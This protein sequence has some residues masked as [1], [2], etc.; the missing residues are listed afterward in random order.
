MN[1][2]LSDAVTMLLGRTT[3][4]LTVRLILQPSMAAF[5]AIRAGL[6]DARAGRTPYLSSVVR[7]QAGQRGGLLREGWQQVRTIFFVA[8]ALDVIYQIMVFRWVY[9]LQAVI[10]AVVLATL[11]ILA[12][13]GALAAKVGGAPMWVG[14]AR[15]TFWGALAMGVTAGVGALFH[16][17]V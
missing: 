7:A 1:E 4:P 12:I 2:F 13:L 10:V 16:I 6:K 11:C 9:P 5:L 8:L 17:A 3:G 15:V 14:T